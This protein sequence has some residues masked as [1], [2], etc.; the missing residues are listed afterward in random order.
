MRKLSEN[1]LLPFG[2]VKRHLKTQSLRLRYLFILNLIK[3]HLLKI[4]FSFYFFNQIRISHSRQF[5]SPKKNHLHWYI[6]LMI[7]ILT[8]EW[9]MYN[10]ES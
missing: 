8:P 1:L 3:L 10:T 9:Y 2:H 4:N 5:S 6:W 7:I